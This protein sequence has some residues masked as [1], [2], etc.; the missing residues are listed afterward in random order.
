MNERQYRVTKHIMNMDFNEAYAIVWN[1][2]EEE[3]EE[4]ILDIGTRTMNLTVYSFMN[5]LLQREE[6]SRF[7]SVTALL[8][9]FPL[10]HMEGAY[11]ISLYHARKAI[12][13]SPE[14]AS[15]YEFVLFFEGNPHV[16]M[17]KEEI[18][19]THMRIKEL[20]NR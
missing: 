8:M 10:C 4:L 13:L 5:Y 1:L 11:T 17:S 15:Y 20:L 19:A 16:Y 18:K 3:L 7:H 12:E 9:A 6:A 2:D 14:D